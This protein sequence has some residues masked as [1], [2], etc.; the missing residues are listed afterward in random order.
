MRRRGRARRHAPA[1]SG[2]QARCE[3]GAHP[4]SPQS[5]VGGARGDVPCRG[6][7]AACGAFLRSCSGRGGMDSAG[8]AIAAR[9]APPAR[10]TPR[11]AARARATP[12]S[13]SGAAN[14]RV[15]EHTRP[16][17][18][19]DADAQCRRLHAEQVGVA[20]CVVSAS[21]RFVFTAAPGTH[22]AC[23][24]ACVCACGLLMAHAG[25][26]QC[27]RALTPARPRAAHAHCRARAAC[28]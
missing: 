17:R 25:A 16:C 4:F 3:S 14:A 10:S 12:T 28:A 21:L 23:T 13:D 27:M 8:S 15:G 11:G 2:S 19:A 7:G 22:C 26:C 6:A 1:L 5:I 24:V 18:E 9:G 20:S